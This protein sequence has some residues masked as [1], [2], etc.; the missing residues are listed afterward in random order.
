MCGGGQFW[1]LQGMIRPL[2]ALKLKLALLLPLIWAGA[3]PVPAAGAA[4]LEGIKNPSLAINA[5]G[6]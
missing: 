6:F 1:E 2:H 4:P 5:T 3:L